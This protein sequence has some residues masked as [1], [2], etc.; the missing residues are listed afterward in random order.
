[1][2]T[3]HSETL[4]LPVFARVIDATRV[5]ALFS[6]CVVSVEAI[7][8]LV[9]DQ[10]FPEERE[11]IRAAV[12]K[13]RA[14]F[15]TA[16]VCARR[17]LSEF[18][19]AAAALVPHADRSPAWPAGIVG[20]ITH[21]Q[22]YCAVAIARASELRSLGL[23]AEVDR[24]LEPGIINMICT[25]EE[26]RVLASRPHGERD[27]IAYFGAK[28]AFYKCQYPLTRTFLDFQDVELDLDFAAGTFSTRSV[29]GPV[30]EHPWLTRLHGSFLRR[31]QLVVC[32]VELV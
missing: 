9:D 30:K 11:C 17:A 16:R 6:D 24:T 32:G 5:Q 25:P 27:A 13:R 15:G 31:D 1:M 10:L 3:P 12:P 26:R 8:A 14:E 28:E 21:T 2:M 23:D 20:S 29:R 22:G 4:E 7:P 19:Y 18:G